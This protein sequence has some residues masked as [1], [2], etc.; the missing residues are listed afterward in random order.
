MTTDPGASSPDAVDVAAVE[1]RSWL[2]VPGDSERKIER[3]AS[4]GADALIY[5]LE[6]A[7]TADRRPA[8]RQALAGVLSRPASHGSERWVRVNPLDSGETLADLAAV[9]TPHVD[10]V[11]V[12]KINSGEDVTVVD[13]YLSALEVAAGAD[14]GS[15][16]IMVVATETPQIMFRLGDLAGSSARLAAVTWGAEDLGTAVGATTNRR[17]DGGWD[18][19]YRLARSLCLFAATSARAQ[20]VDTLV[21]DFND[22]DALIASTQQARRQGF[23]GKLAIHPRQ[24]PIINEHL[25]P[26]DEEVAG[27]EA[28]I[29]AFG[30]QHD[31]GTVQLDGRMLDRPHLT[32]AQRVVARSR[33]IRDRQR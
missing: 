20:P 1:H 13:H 2:F 23:T 18:D 24:V 31:A 28:V 25:A 22:D 29:A 10:G 16:R 11:V 3:A 7:V 21:A 15:V 17:P 32:Q 26:T 8:A 33:S 6:D 5:D 4:V 14:V 19:P 9:V 30:E 12:P 27:A